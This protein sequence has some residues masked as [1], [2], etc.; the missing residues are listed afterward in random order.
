[1]D[2]FGDKLEQYYGNTSVYFNSILAMLPYMISDIHVISQLEIQGIVKHWIEIGLRES[3]A[4]PDKVS[5]KRLSALAF[6]CDI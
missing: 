6:I 4:D 1:M 3:E 5:P 2:L